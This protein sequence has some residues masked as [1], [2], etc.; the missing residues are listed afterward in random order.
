MSR[1]PK[2][3]T[4]SIELNHTIVPA[5]NQQASAQFLADILGVPVD[6]PTS[7]F[8]AITL[9]NRVTLDY[10]QLRSSRSENA[11]SSARATMFGNMSAGS[12]A[13]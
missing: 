4:M 1:P 9:A 11:N 3:F 6:P 5:H 12:D 10:D 2:E 7:H 8:T 13:M